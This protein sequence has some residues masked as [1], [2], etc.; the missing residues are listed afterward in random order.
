VKQPDDP[1]EKTEQVIEFVDSVAGSGKTTEAV[2]QALRSAKRG[3]KTIFAMPTLRLINEWFGKAH[4]L[5]KTRVHLI[6]SETELE[7][8]VTKSICEHIEDTE[9]GHLL[10][11]THAA[12]LLVPEW[13]D[14]T[15]EYSLIIDEVFEAI[16][17]RSPFR[18]R[19]SSHILT[20]FLEVTSV[21][22]SKSNVV[23][24]FTW[25][26]KR[27]EQEE[28][29]YYRVMP[30]FD[31]KSDNPLLQT[32]L[33]DKNK[34]SDDVYSLIQP[35][36]HWLM[37]GAP[38]FTDTK[39]WNRMLAKG[40]SYN[41]GL[42]TIS[43]FRRPDMLSA[44]KSVTIMSALFRHSTLYAVWK[45]LGVN[46]TPSKTLTMSKDTT[47]LGKRRLTIYW[48]TDQGW[49]KKARTKSGGIVPI[50][51]LI[52]EKDVIDL[53]STV[54]VNVNKDDGSPESPSLVRDVF[55]KAEVMDFDTRGRNDY[56]DNHQLIHGAAL[57]SYTPDIRYIETA[58]E[59]GSYEQR[60]ARLGLQVYQT[61][62]RLS[63]RKEGATSDITVVVMDKDVA[64][65][66]KQHFDPI[67]NVEV[68]EINSANVIK[69]RKN[70]RP[71]VGDKPMTNAERK[72]RW[73]EKHNK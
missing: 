42:I 10:F 66:L 33:R 29:P 58:L 64:E 43:G 15:G 19:Y 6:T 22:L 59:I 11:I 57:N 8:A 30:K 34:D 55:P 31:N 27:E 46:F 65:W 2:A 53:E 56:S 73:R 7:Q 1:F 68:I 32:E 17:T 25:K 61:I 26:E 14:R 48:L 13:P 71:R 40:N 67:S 24:L 50:L 47:P 35:I 69:T 70:G 23:D 12:L 51:E 37:R 36:P 60:I 41:K 54:C 49:S 3:K 52:K 62:L 20:Q 16:L 44:F 45:K 21:V 18:L 72:R 63:L 28:E 4:E 39:R 5:D 9:G 38:L